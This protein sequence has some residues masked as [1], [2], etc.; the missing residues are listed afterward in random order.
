M[1]IDFRSLNMSEYFEQLKENP[2]RSFVDI[3]AKIERDA[4]IEDHLFFSVAKN[5]RDA[6]VLWAS[7]E[8][9]VTNPFSQ[10]LFQLIGNVRN[11]HIRSILIPIVGGEHSKVKQGTATK[12]HPWLIWKLCR[13]M[14]IQSADIK[15]TKAIVDFIEVL[16]TSVENPMY[17]LGV[18]GIGNELMLLAEY[19][20]VESCFDL[21]FP[22]AEYKD[23]LHANIGEDEVHSRLIGDAA[24]ALVGLGFKSQDFVEGAKAGVQARVA[25]YDSLLTEINNNKNGV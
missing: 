20:A 12:S 13:S 5:R 19:K 15:P 2:D 11:V 17:G 4:R 23:F 25:Y 1:N 6:M 10:I 7:Q 16:A 21:A 3:A 14:G 8:V 24:A 18:L 22:E 9:I